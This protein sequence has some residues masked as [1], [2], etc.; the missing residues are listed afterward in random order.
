MTTM[1]RSI[2]KKLIWN[3]VSR[4]LMIHSLLYNLQEMKQLTNRRR[5][6]RRRSASFDNT[7]MTADIKEATS[8]IGSEIATTSQV[9]CKAIGVYAEFSEKYTPM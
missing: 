5:R 7:T 3:Q 1:M 8:I 2:M 6:R 4:T 9:L